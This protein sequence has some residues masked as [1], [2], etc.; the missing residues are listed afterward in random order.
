MSVIIEFDRKQSDKKTQNKVMNELKEELKEEIKCVIGNKVINDIHEQYNTVFNDKK[1]IENENI[2]IRLKNILTYYQECYNILYSRIN[3]YEERQC[4]R[5]ISIYKIIYILNIFPKELVQIIWNYYVDF[6]IIVE[7]SWRQGLNIFKY[8]ERIFNIDK[9]N[10]RSIITYGRAEQIKEGIEM[11]IQFYN[12]DMKDFLIVEDERIVQLICLEWNNL[13]NF[14]IDLENFNEPDNKKK[15]NIVTENYMIMKDRVMENAIWGQ[16]KN[17]KKTIPEHIIKAIRKFSENKYSIITKMYDNFFLGIVK[18]ANK[19]IKD[20]KEMK[21]VVE[22][23]IPTITNINQA[24]VMLDNNDEDSE[25]DDYGNN[26]HD[27]DEW[28][29]TDYY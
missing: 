21:F 23:F 13:N 22:A 10:W 2:L 20:L 19:L 1:L 26:D 17:K 18:N 7:Y 11:D 4:Y 24:Y 14:I 16:A 12:L 15:Y 5:D 28:E 3:I 25:G 8:L 27:Y 6:E 29:E 9:Y